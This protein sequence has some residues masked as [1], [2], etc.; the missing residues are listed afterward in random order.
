MRGD[1]KN[2]DGPSSKLSAA[3][4][5]DIHGVPKYHVVPTRFVALG[6]ACMGLLF[7]I[8][9]LLALLVVS[10]KFAIDS[11]EDKIKVDEGQNDNTQ[12]FDR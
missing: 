7:I 8:A 9:I 10:N 2:A 4:I 12:N 5:V 3:T 6:L 11:L 1:I